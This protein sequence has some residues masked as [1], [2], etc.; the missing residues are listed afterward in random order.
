MTPKT[1]V[2]AATVGICAAQVP[3]LVGSVVAVVR[4]ASTRQMTPLWAVLLTALLVVFIW[5]P[6]RWD[7]GYQASHQPGRFAFAALGLLLSLV[8]GTVGT[9][10]LFAGALGIGALGLVT[11]VSVAALP[12]LLRA[13]Y[14]AERD[15]I[16]V[17][18]SDE[19][20][21]S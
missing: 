8:I 18:R 11:S 6:H 3:L 2:L 21:E 13:R 9:E 10:Q 7:A 14:R 20:F 1:R 15:Q 4:E 19:E 5:L 16:I 12:W 17:V